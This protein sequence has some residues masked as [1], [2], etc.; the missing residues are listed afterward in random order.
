MLSQNSYRMQRFGQAGVVL[1]AQPGEVLTPELIAAQVPSVFAEEKHHSRSEKYT[2]IPTTDLL[3]QM[4]REDVYPM[5]I[6]QG[7][8]KHEDKL[9]FTKHLIRF[10]PMQFQSIVLHEAFPEI[11]LIN[12]HDGTSS[13]QLIPGWF[14]MVCSNGLIIS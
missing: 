2:Y 8:S 9:G 5:E 1:R 12:S 11:I 13:Y 6:R 10:R 7:G 14:R 3:R 4:A